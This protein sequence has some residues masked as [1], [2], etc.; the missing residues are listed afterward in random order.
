[1]ALNS[2]RSAICAIHALRAARSRALRSLLKNGRI[3]DGTGTPW[4]TGD[5][6]IRG[7]AIARSRRRSTGRRRA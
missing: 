1:M 7:D 4:F 3:V 5:V 6:A 2:R